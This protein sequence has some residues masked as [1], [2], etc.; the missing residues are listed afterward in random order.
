LQLVEAREK[1]NIEDR[2]GWRAEDDGNDAK[3]ST[4]RLEGKLYTVSGERRREGGATKD[5]NIIIVIRVAY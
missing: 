3:Y 4:A 1:D 5:T 2:Y